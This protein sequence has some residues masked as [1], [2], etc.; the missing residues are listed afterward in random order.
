[1]RSEGSP[2]TIVRRALDRGSLTAV[3][4]AVPNLPGP[5]PLEDALVICLLLR[6]QEP[7]RYERAALKWLGRLLREQRGVSLR[8]AELAAAYLAAW[9][10][11]AAT[12][13]LGE[14]GAQSDCADWATGSRPPTATDRSD[15]GASPLDPRRS[16]YRP[17]A[18][19][20]AGVSTLAGPPNPT[21]SASSP[22]RT[23]RR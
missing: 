13:A 10:D 21:W 5:P 16:P 18:A 15:R 20:A 3:R 22:M 9:A 6:D 1:M 23:A 11:H 12:E 8:H 2:Y 7:D 17:H 4:A 14:L 19:G